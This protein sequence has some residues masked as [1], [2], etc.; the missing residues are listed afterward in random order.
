M[1]LLIKNGRVIDPANQRD[2]QFDVLVEKGRILKVAPQGKLAPAETEGAK[3]IDATGCVVTPGFLDMHVHFREPGF[4]YKETI[5]TGCE[6]AAA[7]GFTTVA[8]MPNT[9]PVNDTRSVTEFMISQAR[10]HAVINALPI[11]AITQ[12]LKGEALTDMGDLK[13]AGAVA[14][15]DDGRPVMSNQLMRRAFEYSRMFDLMLIQ[16]SEIL[17]LTKGGCMH[18]GSISTELG[19]GGMPH[20]AEDIMVYRDIALL[21]KTGGRLHVAHISSGNAVELVRRA[22][23]QGLPVTTEVAPHHF[24][25]TD[26]AVR[27]YDTNTKMSPPLRSDR[28]IEL[29]KEGLR[30][31][32]IDMIATDHAP[33]DVVDKQLEYSHACFGVVGLETAL[34]L[35]LKLVDENILTLPQMVEKLTSRPAE[36]FRLDKGTLKEGRDADITIFD[37]QA[38]YT[39]DVM[40]FKS[41]S[42]NSPF[43]GWQVKGKV[44]HTIYRGKVVYS[45]PS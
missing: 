5:Q 27:G 13:D 24:M 36:V 39:V 20:E 22:K 1:K 30:D 16:H 18:E 19:L 14:L 4:E 10:A 23:Q 26:A 37:P 28:D 8:M 21:E 45:N 34:P 12:G 35:S 7:G 17:D 29:I 31:G 33:H 11:A 25:L 43:H 15:S 41:K 32:T 3:E 42:K 44:M 38:E 40:K 6:S 9:N 2:G